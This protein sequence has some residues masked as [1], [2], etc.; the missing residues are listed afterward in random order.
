MAPSIMAHPA[1]ARVLPDLLACPQ[2]AAGPE[3]SPTSG[4]VRP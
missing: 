4:G 1:P 2:D 3:P